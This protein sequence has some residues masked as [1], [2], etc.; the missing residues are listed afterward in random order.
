LKRGDESGS[1]NGLSATGL[2]P[3][4]ATAAASTGVDFTP[5]SY[6]GSTF[7]SDHEHYV[8]IAG[9]AFTAAVFHRRRGRT[10]R[11]RPRAAL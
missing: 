4:F 11:T 5:P 1:I 3:G 2:S 7:T 9:G 10:A 6:G 8:A